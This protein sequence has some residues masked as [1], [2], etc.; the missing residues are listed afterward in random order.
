[1]SV[2]NMY[3]QIAVRYEDLVLDSQYIGPVWIEKKLHSLKLPFRKYLDLGCA[4]GTIGTIISE[5]IP[6]SSIVG[7]DV[8]PEMIRIAE[9]R[10]IYQ[11]LHVHNLD[12][13]L[14]HLISNDINVVTAL[15]FSE[16]LSNPEQL[17][18][19]V[20]QL[21]SAN[22]IC[23][24]SFQ[25]HDPSNAKLPRM[26]HSGEVVHNAYTEAEVKSM[27]E[28]AGFNLTKLETLRGYVS[29]KGY[30]CYYIMVEASKA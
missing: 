27:F 29:S 21:L 2:S 3:D 14:G 23:F 9:S 11:S 25:L 13:P 17:L 26:T 16:F 28:R 6:N 8:S 12:E 22:G 10:N 30:E 24:M 15:G 7:I 5:L 1:M 18:K 20:H 19:E 4:T